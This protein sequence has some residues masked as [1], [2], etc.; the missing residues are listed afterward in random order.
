MCT[1]DGH[2]DGTMIWGRRTHLGR[3]NT[4]RLLRART[5]RAR[6]FNIY[7]AWWLRHHKRQLAKLRKSPNRKHS[8]WSEQSDEF[9][10]EERKYPIKHK[11]PSSER[12][13][14][15]DFEQESAYYDV[16]GFKDA[17]K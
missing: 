11:Y 6:E 13:Q 17:K 10:P 8:R 2:R 16:T 7:R 12:Y 3:I 1:I 4:E 15:A 9:I 14:S 5:R